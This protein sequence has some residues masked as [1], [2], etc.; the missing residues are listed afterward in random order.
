MPAIKIMLLGGGS[1]YFT[2]VL[3][4]LALER[5]LAG[6]EVVLYDIDGEK[7]ER[8]ADLGRRLSDRA[9]ASL[10]F[11]GT[12]DADAAGGLVGA[13]WPRFSR[14]T[15]TPG[16]T[17]D[18]REG[19]ADWQPWADVF[20]PPD[21]F[22]SQPEPSPFAPPDASLTGTRNESSVLFSL[23]NLSS[24][25]PARSPETS[26]ASQA[27]PLST[28]VRHTPEQATDAPRS[29]SLVS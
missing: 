19:M 14:V 26:K 3:G 6:S 18:W 8:M 24:L 4:N 17:R 22:A 13:S 9:G 12:A 16:V 28:T 5:E 2:R 1:I 23:S 7:A 10:R 27:G 21:L 29:M 20:A 15:T 25:T 11:T